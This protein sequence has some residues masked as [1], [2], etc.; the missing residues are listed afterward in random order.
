MSYTGYT[1]L[2]RSTTEGARKMTRTA[3]GFVLRGVVVGF[4]RGCSP[5]RI[6]RQIIGTYGGIRPSYRVRMGWD[7]GGKR[8][9]GS[10]RGQ[11][12]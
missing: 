1:G 7:K 5:R 3:M 11:V 10:G 9:V 2:V 4:R 12:L 8:L 6:V